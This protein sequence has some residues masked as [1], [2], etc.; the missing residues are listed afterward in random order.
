MVQGRKPAELG[1]SA[2]RKRTG[3]KQSVR[4]TQTREKTRLLHIMPAVAT[5]RPKELTM[6]RNKSAN[7][8]QFSMIPRA[9]IPRSSFRIQKTH[10]TTFDSGYLVPIYVDE[11]LPGDSFNLRMTAFCRLA[12]P[13]FPIMDN[14]KMDTFF[15]FVP[16]RLS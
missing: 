12:T 6:F 7:V 3:R 11:V 14:L 4:P 8:H 5:K 16:S 1:N 2:D 13:L 9:S 15:F 10:K